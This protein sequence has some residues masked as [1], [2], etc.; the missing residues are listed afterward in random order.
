MCACFRHRSRAHVTQSVLRRQCG[1][2]MFGTTRHDWGCA[3]QRVRLVV[4]SVSNRLCVGLCVRKSRATGQLIPLRDSS[5]DARIFGGEPSVSVVHRPLHTEL[6]VCCSRRSSI[7]RLLY[8]SPLNP[9]ELRK[10]S[11]ADAT[12]DADC[13]FPF[14][15]PSSSLF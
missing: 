10:Q 8:L 7:H 3:V 13:D 5:D 9:R 1:C 11:L 15:P 12:V 14:S 4:L 6:L 2:E